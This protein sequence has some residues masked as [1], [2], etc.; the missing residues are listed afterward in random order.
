MQTKAILFDID[1]TLVDSNDFHVHAWKEAFERHGF[2]L[3]P[4]VIH[5]QI[6]KGGDNLLPAL[7]PEADE[8]VR[9]KVQEAHGEIFKSRY[10]P[11]VK[12]FP[13][14][15]DLIERTQKSGRKAV[16]ASS[17]ARDELERHVETIGAADFISG[18]T[19][20]DDVESSK[21]SP[22]IFSAAR[23]K[24][25]GVAPEEALVIG[26]T[27]YDMQAARRCG[28]PAIAVR[29]GGFEDDALRA[30]GASAIFDDVAEIC[31]RF[32]E[33]F[34]TAAEAGT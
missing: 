5:G 26:D 28:I 13:G 4:S 17:A 33:L 7:L 27:P 32:D 29:S 22:D 9:Q 30:A 3:E 19:S 23:E 11:R 6:G 1:G 15:R 10:L 18:S 34:R 31:A 24:L 14:A 16:L 8:E 21:P 20:K 2:H 25:D 12:P